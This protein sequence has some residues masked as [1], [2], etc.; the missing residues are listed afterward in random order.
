MG[1]SELIGVAA[2]A[3][4]GYILLKKLEPLTNAATAATNTVSTYVEKVTEKVENVNIVTD[5]AEKYYTAEGIAYG[6]GEK[7][8][9]NVAL[10]DTDKAAANTVLANADKV[11][12]YALV[13]NPAVNYGVD[14][15]LA[16]VQGGV[17]AS[18]SK[19]TSASGTLKD[20]SLN[21]GTT[22]YAPATAADIKQAVKDYN[23]ITGTARAASSSSSGSGT[24]KITTLPATVKASKGGYSAARDSGTTVN[25]GKYETIKVK[26]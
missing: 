5:T 15:A 26:K 20:T 17:D 7:A 8:G 10:T 14:A 23:I 25:K 13:T 12:N 16:Y 22:P 21:T 11:N 2:I 19:Y 18:K 9:A 3:A 6:L 1:K 4:L 24:A